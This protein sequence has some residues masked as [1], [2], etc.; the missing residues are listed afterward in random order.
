MDEA[1]KEIITEVL[2]EQYPKVGKELIEELATDLTEHWHILKKK[3]LN[4]DSGEWTLSGHVQTVIWDKL[5]EGA[6]SA[7]AAHKILRRMAEEGLK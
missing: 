2:S 6:Q 1:R 4:G 3:A 7:T 5:A